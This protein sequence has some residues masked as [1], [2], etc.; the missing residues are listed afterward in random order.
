MSPAE[1]FVQDF[2]RACAA[3][4][5]GALAALLAEEVQGL[6]LSGRWAE[7]RAAMEAAWGADFGGL[8]S[9]ARLVRGK[10]GHKMLGPGAA[11]LHQRFIVSGALAA[12]DQALP[13]FPAVLS[14][15]LIARPDGWQ[16]VSL[17]FQAVQEG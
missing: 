5:A 16:A 17:T 13:R 10:L 6:T 4:D 3:L 9:Q 12:E 2:A 8:L 14:V 15:V 11:V 7:G 1:I